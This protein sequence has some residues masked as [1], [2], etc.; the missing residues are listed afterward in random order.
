MPV[1]LDQLIISLIPQY[2]HS[3]IF[4]FE[5]VRLGAFTKVVF[6]HALSSKC[7]LDT[8]DRKNDLLFTR[9]AV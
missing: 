9:S 5:T 2:F 1:Y 4:L 6:K 8:V 3:N 7:F